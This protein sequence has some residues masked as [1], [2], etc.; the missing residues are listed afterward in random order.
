[1]VFDF[2][3]NLGALWVDVAVGGEGV[4]WLALDV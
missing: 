3:G 4:A 2:I 1:M